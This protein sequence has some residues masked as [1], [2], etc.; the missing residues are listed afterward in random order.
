LGLDLQVCQVLI[1]V[2]TREI[3]YRFDKDL[4]SIGAFMDFSSLVLVTRPIRQ[5]IEELDRDKPQILIGTPGGINNLHC[6]GLLNF[7]SLKLLVVDEAD[8]LVSVLPP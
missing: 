6:R 5:I 7:D 2:P 4:K 1:L 3:A 8:H